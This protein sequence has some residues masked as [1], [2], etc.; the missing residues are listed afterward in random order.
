M[1]VVYALKSLRRNFIYVGFTNNLNKRLKQ[2][3]D[4]MSKSTKPYVPFKLIYREEVQTRELARMRE[5]QLK[6]GYGKEF[7]KNLLI[8]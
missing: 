5:K 1:Y 8:N 2:H 3:S 7:L 4:G 6:S